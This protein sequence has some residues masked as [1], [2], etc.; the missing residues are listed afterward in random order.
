M[1]YLAIFSDLV[2]SYRV[3]LAKETLIKDK[4][5]SVEGVALN[6]GFNSRATFYRVF[7]KHTG[8]SPTEYLNS[9]E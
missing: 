8:F 1:L 6:S 9:L 2:N 5:L 3:E 7:K 4:H